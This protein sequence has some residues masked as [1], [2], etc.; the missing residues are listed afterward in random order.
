MSA[1]FLREL[2]YFNECLIVILMCED[3]DFS[4]IRL[5]LRTTI[6]LM[7]YRY[8]AVKRTIENSESK[9][10]IFSQCRRDECTVREK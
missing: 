3:E 5:N 7:L 8:K 4:N 1:I 2:L 6:H 9:L 10:S